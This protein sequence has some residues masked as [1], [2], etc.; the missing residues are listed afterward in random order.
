MLSNLPNGTQLVV[1][2]IAAQ[3]AFRSRVSFLNTTLSCPEKAFGSKSTLNDKQWG[4]NDFIR[5]F[6]EKRN[7]NKLISNYI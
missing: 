7:E 1:E 6:L 3:V 5:I 4:K 2:W